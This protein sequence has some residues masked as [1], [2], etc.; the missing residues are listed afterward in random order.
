MKKRGRT[1]FPLAQA[2]KEK[3]SAKKVKAII[4]KMA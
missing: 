3:K 1:A 4:Q 2:E